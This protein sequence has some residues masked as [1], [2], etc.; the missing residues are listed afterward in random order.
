[1]ID[2]RFLRTL[3]A[4][5]EKLTGTTPPVIA[6]HLATLDAIHA[7]ATDAQRPDLAVLAAR[8]E[9]TPKNVEKLI[10]EAA[11][12]QPDYG[13]AREQATTGVLRAARAD[14][15]GDGGDQ[16]IDALRPVWDEHWAGIHKARA[17]GVTS[18]STADQVLA[19]DDP[20][21]ARLWR[22]LADHRDA[23]DAV[24]ALVSELA[25]ELLPALN[26]SHLPDTRP[27]LYA[28]ALM[29]VDDTRSHVFDI[30]RLLASPRRTERGGIWLRATTL[31]G[32]ELRR[33]AEAKA[34]AG[35][36]IAELA[37]TAHRE[38]AATHG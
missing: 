30:G 26:P 35:A 11:A 33:I 17:A 28:R 13:T 15:L 32:V 19:S 18:S 1:M 21:A 6:G 23:L 20:D 3:A 9:L 5:V 8:G 25:M 4:G 14:L 34:S 27:L 24:E 22:E 2:E 37:D 29:F 36:F 31:P 38:Y 7:V 12:P 10:H 16:I